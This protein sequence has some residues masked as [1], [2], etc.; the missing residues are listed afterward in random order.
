MLSYFVIWINTNGCSLILTAQHILS[1]LLQLIDY[2]HLDVEK[3]CTQTETFKL[4]N[5]MDKTISKQTI[6]TVH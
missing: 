6:S 2:E 1:T 3:K 5:K 4:T